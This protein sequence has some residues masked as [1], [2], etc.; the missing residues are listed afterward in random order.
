MLIIIGAFLII[1]GI[2]GGHEWYEST[3]VH[4]AWNN[5][6]SMT[7]IPPEFHIS[8]HIHD[9]EVQ[10]PKELVPILFSGLIGFPIIWYFTSKRRV[11]P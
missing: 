5:L 7:P 6:V 3:I 11:L 10:I 1:Q 2:P 9:Y 4:I 8:E